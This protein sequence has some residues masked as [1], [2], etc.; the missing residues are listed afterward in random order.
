MYR[1]ITQNDK[2]QKQISSKLSQIKNC[3]LG[4]FH[5]VLSSLQNVRLKFLRPIFSNLKLQFLQNFN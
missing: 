4:K 1:S 5:G 2:I 3:Q